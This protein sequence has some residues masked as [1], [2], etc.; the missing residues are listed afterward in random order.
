MMILKRLKRL[1]IFL[2]KL[3]LSDEQYEKIVDFLLPDE[4][5]E[6]I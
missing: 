2:C 6:Q 3:D 1:I 4:E 5:A